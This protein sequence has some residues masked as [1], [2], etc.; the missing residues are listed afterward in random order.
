MQ[1]VEMLHPPLHNHES[2]F[3]LHVLAL[4]NSCVALQAKD[5]A[6]PN[7][8]ASGMSPLLYFRVSPAKNPLCL[9]IMPMWH[10]AFALIEFRGC[11][12]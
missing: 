4:L 8:R 12:T 10:L 7:R 9:A 3:T 11:V 2:F 1:R 5:L 6:K